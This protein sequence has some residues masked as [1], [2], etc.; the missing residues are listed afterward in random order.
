MSELRDSAVRGLWWNLFNTTSQTVLQ[1]AQ[2]LILA[3]LLTPADYGLAGMAYVM[4]GFL[5]VFQ[6]MGFSAVVVQRQDLGQ[7]QL[8]SLYWLNI[9]AGF[10]LL[11]GM[12]GLGVPASMFYSMPELAGM[13]AV[14][15]LNFLV[16]SSGLQYAWLAE[17]DLKFS[18]LSRLDIASGMVGSLASIALA[19]GGFGAWSIVLG[20]TCAGVVRTIALVHGGRAHWKPTWH[21]SWSDLH[22]LRRFGMY[23]MAE[24]TLNYFNSRVDQLVLGRL[25]GAV[26]L[27]LYSFGFN[28][29]SR[30]SDKTNP[31]VTRVAFPVLAKVQH[32]KERQKA[33]YLFVLHSL[34]LVNAP[35]HLG[36]AAL[37]PD[38]VPLF[39]HVKWMPAVPVLQIIAAVYL[40]RSTGNPVGALALSSGRAD[41]TFWWNVIAFTVTPA[42]VV[43]GGWFGGLQGIAW[44]LLAT[45]LLYFWPAYR[46]MVRP[47][48]GGC[49]PA[50]AAAIFRPI[51]LAVLS[52]AGMW[53]LGTF[54][55]PGALRLAAMAVSGI[56]LYLALALTLDRTAVLRTWSLVRFRKLETVA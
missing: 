18:W 20:Q 7:R 21:F 23:Q 39:F 19:F 37:A 25:L 14:L 34:T 36:F 1:M 13:M 47:I 24:R 8:S 31:V 22:G 11:L 27:G 51:G 38:I 54:M 53:W 40:M 43:A 10:G 17:R 55:A 15:G 33:I 28:L 45:Q 16:L 49:L 42:A 6:D 9:F 32:D 50:Y 46:L 2:F 44:A 12:S 41:L 52:T 5:Q 35:L 26:E 3:R 29:A 30:L 48:L 4:S 56:V